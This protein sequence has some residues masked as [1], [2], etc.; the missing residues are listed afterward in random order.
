[1]AL[2]T[3]EMGFDLVAGEGNV[4]LTK[5]LL[6]LKVAVTVA[7][8]MEMATQLDTEM[9]LCCWAVA[10]NACQVTKLIKVMAATSIISAQ[11]IYRL[12]W[13]TVQ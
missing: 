12:G 2:T 9:K 1:M 3:M 7:L 8:T 4:S 13:W 6:A 11:I 10:V 5:E